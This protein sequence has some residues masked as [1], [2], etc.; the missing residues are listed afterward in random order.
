MK[1]TIPGPPVTPA[2]DKVVVK[3]A[4][5]YRYP[6]A[7]VMDYQAKIRACWRSAG[8]C[9]MGREDLLAMTITVHFAIPASA[10]KKQ[11][12]LMAR[13]LHLPARRPYADGVASLVCGTLSGLAFGDQRQIARLEVAKRYTTDAPG[14]TVEIRR[15]TEGRG[16]C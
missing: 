3:G 5:A 13:G 7:K 15:L 1:F 2:P 12:E 10:C 11:R 6:S 8:A 14:V 4:R 9:A 16:T